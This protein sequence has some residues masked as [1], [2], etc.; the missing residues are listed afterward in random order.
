MLLA[1]KVAVITG[2]ASGIGRA[3]AELFAREGARVI[4]ADVNKDG[5]QVADQI[6]RQG[7]EASFVHTNLCS[8]S[9]IQ[10]MIKKTIE[11]YGQVD[12]FWHNAGIAGPGGIEHTTEETYED[13]MAIHLK[14]SVFGA[15]CAIP[16]M[17]KS[18][19]GCILFTSSISGL[20]A[21]PFSLTYSLAK[22]GLVMLTRCLASSLARKN[23][24]V[25]CICPAPVDT[26]LLD[27]VARRQGVTSEELRRVSVER[28][29]M[30]RYVT[31]DE[32]T[33]AALFLVSDNASAITGVALP[34]DGGMAA[35]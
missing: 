29:P 17:E 12:I 14:A 25:N 23:I 13:T 18:G 4:I 6:K 30:G 8:V 26:P 10:N 5:Q 19:G 1:G 24:R 7:N 20:R 34:V 32:V 11:K 22:A 31:L 21:S 3:G 9:D 16:E 35:V 2:A 27:S 33:Q 28:I 15:K